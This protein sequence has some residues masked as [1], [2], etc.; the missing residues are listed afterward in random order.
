[1][2]KLTL[3]DVHICCKSHQGSKWRVI[4]NSGCAAPQPMI[5]PTTKPFLRRSQETEM[6]SQELLKF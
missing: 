3:R 4:L 1:M 2:K 6:G 5:L